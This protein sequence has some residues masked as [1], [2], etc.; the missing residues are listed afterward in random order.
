MHND[1][2]PV[3]ENHSPHRIVAIE[4]NP[5]DTLL[6]RCAL[7]EIGEPYSLEVLSDGEAA[8]NFVRNHCGTHPEPCLVVLDLHLPKYDGV[9]VL[10]AIRSEPRISHVKV[11]V[12]TSAAS[13]METAEILDLGVQ[14]YRTKPMQWTGVLELARELLAVC[15]GKVLS[16]AQ[17]A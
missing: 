15:K 9:A 4:D 6:L 8:L 11:V 13:P 1:T 2:Y 5:G 10:R 12:L 17:M 16:I 14:G 7:D 3:K